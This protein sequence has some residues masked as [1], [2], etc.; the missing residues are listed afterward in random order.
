MPPR[1][2]TRREARTFAPE[3][4]CIGLAGREDAV[5]ALGATEGIDLSLLPLTHAR[6]LGDVALELGVPRSCLLKDYVVNATNSL[7]NES[8]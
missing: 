1:D 7:F 5:K 6:H 4:S 8:Q 2:L 3:K